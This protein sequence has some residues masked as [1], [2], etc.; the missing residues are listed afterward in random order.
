MWFKYYNNG[1]VPHG[2]REIGSFWWKDLLRLSVL[3][4][5]I[6][7]CQI[8]DGST[9]LFWDDL[10]SSEVLALK[11]LILSSCARNRRLSVKT[12]MQTEDLNTLFI[13]PLS[14]QA[15]V[16]FQHL[17]Q[18]LLLVPYEEERTDR[19]SFMWGSLEYSSQKIFALA[20]RNIETPTT[21]IC[22]WKSKCIPRIKFFGWLILVDRLNT[23]SML[24][25]RHFHLED[26]YA[27]VMCPPRC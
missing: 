2:A 6:A 26:G 7:R 19:W 3:C 11:C 25:R 18:D 8:G 1:K 14:E 22:L 16:Q 5:G 15:Y 21:F 20:L 17:Q 9:V 4:R 27:C 10:W 13:L 12:V 24:R 23:R